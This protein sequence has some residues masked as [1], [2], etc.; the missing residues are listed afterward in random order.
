MPPSVAEAAAEYARRGSAPVL[1]S[2]REKPPVLPEWQKLR[3]TLADI[4]QYFNGRGQNVGL[5]LGVGGLTDVDLD[6]S[7]AAAAAR[8]LLPDTERRAGAVRAWLP[9]R[10]CACFCRRAGARGFARGSRSAACPSLARR[11]WPQ[12]SGSCAGWRAGAKRLVRG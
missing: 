3:L 9:A 8:E 11:G 6:A 2:H 1:V 5:L 7:E 12:P 10:A 4:P